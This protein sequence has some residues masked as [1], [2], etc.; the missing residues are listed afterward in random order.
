MTRRVSTTIATFLLALASCGILAADALK[1]A[2]PEKPGRSIRGPAYFPFEKPARWIAVPNGGFE[3]SE[4]PEK[5]QTQGADVVTA[6]DAPEGKRYLRSKA[7]LSA[8]QRTEQLPLEP[9]RFYLFSMWLRSEQKVLAALGADTDPSVRGLGAARRHIEGTGGEWK[10]VGFYFRMPATSSQLRINLRMYGK[11]GKGPVDIDDVRLREAPFAEFARAWDA[12]RAQWP[13]RDLAPRPGDGR[14]LQLSV[15]KLEGRGVP[16]KPYVIWAL[17]SSYTNFLGNGESF[18]RLLRARYPDAPTI[19]YKKHVGNST[20]WRFVR[21]WANQFAADEL[22]D[23]IFVYTIGW[24]DRLETMLK[25]L[26][27]RTTADIVVPSIHVRGRGKIDEALAGDAKWVVE[28]KKLCEKYDVEFVANRKEWAEYVTE[29]KLDKQDMLASKKPTEVHQNARGAVTILENVVRHFAPNDKPGYEPEARERWIERNA[30]L[31]E[32]G[33]KATCEFTGRHVMLVGR[34]T[35]GGGTARVLVDGKPAGEVAA[36]VT[37][38]IKPGEKNSGPHWPRGDKAP[39][40]VTLGK[41]VVPQTWTIA[42]TSGTGDFKIEGSATGADGKG[43]A[44]APFTS[45]SGQI[46]I[47]PDLWRGVGRRRRGP[48]KGEPYYHMKKGDTY[49]FDVMRGVPAAVSF[50]AAGEDEAGRFCLPI[51]RNLASGK[52]TLELVAEGDGEAVVEGFY[53]YEPPLKGE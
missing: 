13:E 12:W 46:V 10:R 29:Y 44:I 20:P 24:N 25:E 36:F 19:V 35:E 37:T 3:S 52:H 23:L 21:G 16:G 42:M 47:D 15:K 8:W 18:V 40:A 5:W 4:K 22:P 26:R 45:E 17:G 34:R 33:A 53:V 32:R 43:N 6:D 31:T 51:A 38:Y 49:T 27:R 7:G 14:F 9:N 48:K 1:T 39:H 50:E 28:L 30:T 11:K 41:N 2:P